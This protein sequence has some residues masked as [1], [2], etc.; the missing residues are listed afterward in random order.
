VAEGGA[1]QGPVQPASRRGAA[2][3]YL[4]PAL[5]PP[6]QRLRDAAAGAGRFVGQLPRW[7]A[8]LRAPR[9][10]TGLRVSYG[11]ERM[12]GRD[13]V[14]YGGLVKFQQ[15][16]EL[17]P[18]A[19]RDFNVLYLG[20]S[21][22][23]PDAR[24]L[25]ALARR[26]G[27]AFV[28]NQNGVCYPGW[29]GPGCERQNRPRARLLAAADHVLYQSAFCKLSAD[30]FYGE[31]TEGWE[32]LH[33]PV[34]V[35]LFVPNDVPPSRPL[36]LLLGGNQYQR[37]RLETALRALA[38]VRRD[39]SDAR[40]LVAG[41]IAWDPDR[42]HAERE[43]A[44]LIAELGLE[45]A[46]ELT[47]AYTR[48]EAPGLM[49]RADMLLHTKYNDPCPTVVLEAMASGLPVVYSASG[50]VPELVGVE[51]GV[52]VPAPL[53]WER[54]HPP[55]PQELAAAVL[56]AAERLPEL[57]GAARAR[58]EA[59]FDLRAWAARHEALFEELALR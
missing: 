2:R 13:D 55:G 57:R 46:V 41:A 12:P 40:L 27:A 50:G 45:G 29:F 10:R 19:P 24:V 23:P 18:N 30:R 25:Q 53:D 3:R 22:L 51:A 36:T 17:L 9:A 49:R 26:R 58:V 38:A 37:Y 39:L 31:R 34:D 44:R 47:G 33:N 59:R 11:Y 7:R 1:V 4:P 35:E 56:A 52:G 28:W 21:S 5:V 8:I 16:S 43:T 6:A 14:V 32:I 48:A 54:D 20:S 42:A 15:L